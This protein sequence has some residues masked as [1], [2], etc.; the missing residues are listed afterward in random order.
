MIQPEEFE[1]V[2]SELEVEEERLRRK[3]S[4]FFCFVDTG[5]WIFQEVAIFTKKEVKRIPKS[6]QANEQ[7]KEKYQRCETA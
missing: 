1:H 5:R 7:G 3:K 6:R 2:R 4:E